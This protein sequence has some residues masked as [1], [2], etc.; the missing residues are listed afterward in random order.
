MSYGESF[1]NVKRI[2]LDPP[3]ASKECIISEVQVATLFTKLV[4]RRCNGRKFMDHIDMADLTGHHPL[5]RHCFAKLE[6]V[7]DDPNSWNLTLCGIIS[8]NICTELMEDW[9]KKMCFRFNMSILIRYG[10]DIQV[11]IDATKRSGYKVLQFYDRIMLIPVDNETC[12]IEE[13]KEPL[14]HGGLLISLVDGEPC[15]SVQQFNRHKALCQ[16]QGRMMNI[17]GKRPNPD[18]QD[19]RDDDESGYLEEPDRSDSPVPSGL[20]NDQEG[21]DCMNWDELT[22]CDSLHGQ[23]LKDLD[24]SNKHGSRLETATAIRKDVWD[25]LS[26]PLNKR[27]CDSQGKVAFNGY[28]HFETKFKPL[29][30]IE[31]KDAGIYVCLTISSMWNQHKCRFGTKCDGKCVCAFATDFLTH[32]VVGDRI[33]RLPNWRNPLGL[34]AGQY[35]VGF[36]NSFCPKFEE[37]LRKERP[38]ESPA[39]IL[40]RLYDMWKKHESTRIFGMECSENCDCIT[41]WESVFNKGLRADEIV[42]L[43]TTEPTE[44]VKK[45]LKTSRSNAGGSSDMG[46]NVDSARADVVGVSKRS[47]ADER[48]S[49]AT[50][51]GNE[52]RKEYVCSFTTSEPMGFY[53]ANEIESD[54]KSQCKVKS[55]CPKTAKAR[56]D[57]IQVG[58]TVVAV[59]TKNKRFPIDGWKILK[60]KYMQSKA[61]GKSLDV[62]FINRQ[63]PDEEASEKRQYS[64][65][66]K[67]DKWNGGALGKGDGWAGGAQPFSRGGPQISHK[68]NHHSV[69]TGDGESKAASG[70]NDAKNALQP[71]T[72]LVKRNMMR[73]LIKTKPKSIMVQRTDSGDRSKTRK[74]VKFSGKDEERQYT[75]DFAVVDFLVPCDGRQPKPVDR[76]RD[77]FESGTFLDALQLLES[78]LADKLSEDDLKTLRESIRYNKAPDHRSQ[79]IVRDIAMKDKILKIF[80]KACRTARHVK[81]LKDW[82]DLNV[83]IETFEY[84]FSP[85]ERQASNGD[86]LVI[87]RKLI[88]HGGKAVAPL[89]STRV[90][91]ISSRKPIVVRQNTMLDRR[92]VFAIELKRSEMGET[93]GCVDILLQDIIG[94]NSIRNGKPLTRQYNLTC[95]SSALSASKVTL[96]FERFNDVDSSRKRERKEWCMTLARILDWIR[97]FNQ[98]MTEKEKAQCTFSVEVPVLGTTLLHS[99]VML[100]EEPLVEKLLDKGAKVSP[101]VRKLAEVDRGDGYQRRGIAILLKQRVPESAATGRRGVATT[102]SNG[103]SGGDDR[104]EATKVI[105]LGGSIPTLRDDWLFRLEKSRG[106]K[107][108]CYHFDGGH[109]RFG[110][111]CYY[112]HVHDEKT[113]PPSIPIPHRCDDHEV[114]VEYR[115]DQF[116]KYWYTTGFIDGNEFFYPSSGDGVKCVK[117]GIWWYR[118]ENSARQALR[119]V[120]SGRPLTVL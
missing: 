83:H 119:A 99:A 25:G 38:G 44:P 116:G 76:I 31:Y 13:L 37:L 62:V 34:K 24:D 36:V 12:L 108:R 113:R 42:W 111:T 29:A 10:I 17:S 88:H 47:R 110:R 18:I 7:R 109:C 51:D 93:L 1:D 89:S 115:K 79:D 77:A 40:N 15:N 2:R 75:N 68:R 59:E 8:K 82:I 57:R 5:L 66:W 3:H 92:R 9:L 101:A 78:G 56:D 49:M 14:S 73:E 100:A 80:M 61:V 55:V 52:N 96:R 95:L 91:D 87:E 94:D 118:T 69:R 53:F 30:A 28:R 112:G 22:V 23:G 60:D 74:R 26:H 63:S 39:D 35:P 11:E 33:K 107:K 105:E 90:D 97:Q 48:K 120:L 84:T 65:L 6:P 27:Q 71:K 70:V 58:T 54:G 72:S 19:Y 67:H 4:P 16:S 21:A 64:L 81:A 41:G 114:N 104:A 50:G 32:H 43:E 102:F 117:T 45:K 106:I 86:G 98:D 103:Q 20:A 85:Q 46:S